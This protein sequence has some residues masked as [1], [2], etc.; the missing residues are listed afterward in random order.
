[1][2][3]AKSTRVPDIPMEQYEEDAC[4]RRDSVQQA[5]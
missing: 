4:G 3:L 1:M 2:E 5:L